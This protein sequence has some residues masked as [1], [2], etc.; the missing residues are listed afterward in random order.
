MGIFWDS[1]KPTDRIQKAIQRGAAAPQR[2]GIWRYL[3]GSRADASVRRDIRSGVRSVIQE[4]KEDYKYETKR[5]EKIEQPRARE[6]YERQLDSSLNLSA[7]R[8]RLD[9]MKRSGDPG[10]ARMEDRVKYAERF[11]ERRMR[12][13][14]LNQERQMRRRE[15]EHRQGLRS[16]RRTQTEQA[17]EQL[18][19]AQEEYQRRQA[20]L[21][22]MY[23]QANVPPRQPGQDLGQRSRPSYT[24]P[25]Q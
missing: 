20:R 24:Q 19:E 10:V 6:R 12:E 15:I 17:Y 3:R 4:A 18:G 21:R 1:K 7:L 25:G 8:R 11:Y 2:R 14:E 13:Y 23:E 16:A 5:L 22:A 9:Q